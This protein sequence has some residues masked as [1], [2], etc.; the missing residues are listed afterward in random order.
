MEVT[1][2]LC[3]RAQVAEGKLFVLG[4]GWNVVGAGFPFPCEVAVLI[5]VP[6]TA[7]NEKHDFVLTLRNEDGELVDRGDGNGIE[8]QGQFEVGRPPGVKPGSAINQNMVFKFGMLQLPP[9][10]YVFEFS[11]ADQVLA[12]RPFQVAEG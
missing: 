3:D 12:R 4:A 7:T 5:E 11:M 2:L 9:S 6:W 10:G 8:I 1:M